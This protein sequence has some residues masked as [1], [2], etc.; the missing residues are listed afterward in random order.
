[1]GHTTRL[2]TLDTLNTR[3]ETPHNRAHTLLITCSL[4]YVG[5]L[6]SASGVVEAGSR[7]ACC[8][9]FRPFME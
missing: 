2:C 8:M 9:A 7:H 4:C 3:R 6:G 1:M 5:C